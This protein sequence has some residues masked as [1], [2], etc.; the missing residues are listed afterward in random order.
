MKKFG[1][2]VAVEVQ[3]VLDR[4]GSPI[5]EEKMDAYNVLTYQ[6]TPDTVL[7]VISCGAGEIAAQRPLNFA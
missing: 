3:S 4:Y 7:Y 5:K 1:L 2:V 6:I